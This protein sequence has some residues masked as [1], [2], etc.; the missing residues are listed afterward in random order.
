MLDCFRTR[1]LTSFLN[2][3]EGQAGES[4]STM[5]KDK[6]AKKMQEY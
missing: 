3:E 5:P 6:L 4:I 1:W 2:K